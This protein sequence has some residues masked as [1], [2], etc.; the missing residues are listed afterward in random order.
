[1][2]VGRVTGDQQR[3]ASAVTATAETAVGEAS[4]PQTRA[5]LWL[6]IVAL[7]LALILWMLYRLTGVILLVILAV[8]FAYLVASLVELACRPRTMGGRA[9]VMPRAL[10]IGIV[11][12]L[13]FGSLGAV[14]AFLLQRLGVQITQFANR[15]PCPG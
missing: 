14:L 7:T 13:I 6:I 15:P 2:A 4:C 9:R 3:R 10:A 12:L 11:Y 5:I 1:M 8:F